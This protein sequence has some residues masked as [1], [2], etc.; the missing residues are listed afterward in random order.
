MD[1]LSYS[2]IVVHISLAQA[3][4]HGSVVIEEPIEWE[5]DADVPPADFPTDEP[6]AEPPPNL[7]DIR[8]AVEGPEDIE[9]EYMEDEPGEE[10]GGGGAPAEMSPKPSQPG[11]EEVSPKPSQGSKPV[12][13]KPS[14]PAKPPAEEP[15]SK[16]F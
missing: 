8:D 12:S 3:M 5:G 6:M 4:G 2:E 1:F 15:A 13:P 14:L 11:K 7:D 10:V 16:L 9:D